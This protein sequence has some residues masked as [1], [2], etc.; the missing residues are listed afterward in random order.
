[1]VMLYL[2]TCLIYF[3]VP[4]KIVPFN[5]QEN[6][7]LE[8][9]LVRVSCV[10]SRGDLPLSIT[11]LKDGQPIPAHLS[12]TTRDFDE[13]SSV[14]SIDPVS[15]KHNGNF[16]CVAQNDAAAVNY[17]AHLLVKGSIVCLLYCTFYVLPFL[18][19]NIG[20]TAIAQFAIT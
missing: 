4:P 7:L 8:G 2:L 1:M 6:H 3:T 20:K 19:T 11:W 12:V 17:T 18:I 15:V 10:V 9:M 14:L 5:F 16:T 13:Y